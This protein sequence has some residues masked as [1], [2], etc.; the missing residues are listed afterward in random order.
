[1]SL[2]NSLP[3]AAFGTNGTAL[4]LTLAVIYKLDR[5]IGCD[6]AVFTGGLGASSYVAL[7]FRQ[8]VPSGMYSSLRI[9]NCQRAREDLSLVLPLTFLLLTFFQFDNQNF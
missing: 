1:M 7:L 8:E 2:R 4:H 6:S 5:G 9:F 3:Q